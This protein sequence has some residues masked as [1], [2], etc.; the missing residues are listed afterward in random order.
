MWNSESKLLCNG[1]LQRE[2]SIY[3]TEQDPPELTD[4]L[5]ITFWKPSNNHLNN[6]P[7]LYSNLTS[8][9]CFVYLPKN[10][11]PLKTIWEDVI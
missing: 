6:P 2:D 9:K 11:I 3:G 8:Y 1:D 5:Q 4:I 7:C 10:L